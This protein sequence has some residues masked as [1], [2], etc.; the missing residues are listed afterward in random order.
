MVSISNVSRLGQSKVTYLLVVI[1][2]G[3]LDPF[4]N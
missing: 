1:P 2:V 3:K 4:Y